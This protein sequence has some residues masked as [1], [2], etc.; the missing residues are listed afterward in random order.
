MV[1]I[2]KIICLIF[3]LSAFTY[4]EIPQ[5]HIV[6][7]VAS[8]NNKDWY[9]KNLDSIFMQAYENYHVMYID[10]NSPDGTGKLIHDYIEKNNLHD[11]ITLISNTERKGSPLANQFMA[12]HA[13]DN[14][15]II[16]IVDGDDWLPH[17]HVFKKIN[18]IYS[19]QD[20][21]LTYGQYQ[22]YPSG[23]RGFNSPMPEYVVTQ[24]K[25][26]EF[27]QIPSHL[28]TFYAGLF[29]KIKKE[30][31]MY[32]GKLF[33]MTGDMAAMMPMIEMARD[34]FKFI[35]EVLYIYNAINPLSEH[36]ISKQLQ[37]KCDLEIRNR[38]RYDKITSPF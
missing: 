37:R 30:D 15:S 5:K 38:K 6:A 17:P 14:Q 11:K 2:K 16:I 36:R 18:E 25:F 21:W 29:K 20:V 33:Q 8:Y 19:T 23:K 35:P 34:H 12:I 28:R 4:G 22:E 1:T 31:L 3:F 7:V 24:N 13:C 26:R 27:T 9:Q 32:E 10:D